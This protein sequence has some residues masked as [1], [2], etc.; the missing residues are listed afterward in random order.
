M[1]TLKIPIEIENQEDYDLI[2]KYQ[3]QYTN[4]FHLFYNLILDKGL[5]EHQSKHCK[6]NNL[7]LMDAW[8]TLSCY[9]EA[10][11]LVK[12]T[13]G[14]KVVFGSKKNFFDL[15]NGLISK[16]EWKE[17]RLKQIYSVG[18]KNSHSNR[19]FKI[20]DE[21]NVVFKP[22]KNTKINITLKLNSKSWKKIIKRLILLQELNE[23]PITYRLDTNYIYI[24]FDEYCLKEGKY[25][26]VKNRVMAI[27]MN[28]NY[29]GYSVIDWKSEDNYHIIDKGVFSIKQLNDKERKAEDSSNIT[30]FSNKRNF[31]IFEISK[32]LIEISKSYKC[33]LFG[34]ERLDV[35][36]KDS[37]KGRRFNRLVNNQWNRSI[38]F[39]NIKKRCNVVGIKF[40]E[41]KAEYSSFI[42]N[43]VYRNEKLPDMILS[44]IEIGRRA[45]EF[46][47]Q[48]ILKEKQ[49]KKNIIFPE[50][51]DKLNKN[52]QQS[53]EELK[54]VFDWKNLKELYE[55][56]KN[57]KCKYRISFEY[58]KVFV[59]SSFLIK[60]ESTL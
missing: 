30:Y 56:L 22:N 18:D 45:Y 27:D 36:S 21:N 52:I 5:T 32:K 14:R 46:N 37:G 7:E 8:F 40:V 38:F 43:V 25:N 12:T 29:I 11:Q 31:E 24:S 13:E 4:L 6:F 3:K 58:S 44:S 33:E 35:E 53:L 9:K 42:G 26:P 28:P 17:F 15:M 51:S 23:E 55:F 57:A 39:E 34:I 20:I 59:I 16:D 2:R 10:S 41:V 60:N 47:L 19:K 50:V 49:V 48:Y 54:I 1:Q